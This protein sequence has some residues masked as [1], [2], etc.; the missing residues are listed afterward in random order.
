MDALRQYLTLWRIILEVVLQRTVE[1]RI[2]WRW[3]ASATYSARSAYRMFFT[4]LTRFAGARP[5]WNVWVPL[6]LKFF[7][8]LAVRGRICTANRRHRH[9]LQDSSA[10]NLCDQ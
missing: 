6:K 5:I 9:G 3:S 4:G 2:T 1:D 8:W 7:T 10:C